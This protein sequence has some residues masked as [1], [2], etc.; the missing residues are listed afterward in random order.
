[1]PESPGSTTTGTP[2]VASSSDSSARIQRLFTARADLWA[3]A[4]LM[5]GGLARRPHHYFCSSVHLLFVCRPYR[6]LSILTYVDTRGICRRG[7][8]LSAGA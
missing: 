2:V 4:E 1:M 5:P 3:Q 8:L 6:Y 7:V